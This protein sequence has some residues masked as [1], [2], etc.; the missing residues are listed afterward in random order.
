MLKELSLLYLSKKKYTSIKFLSF[1]GGGIHVR[2]SAVKCLK[3]DYFGIFL[4]L[5]LSTIAPRNPQ[6]GMKK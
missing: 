5:E 4:L 3:E 2:F 1:L 6:N